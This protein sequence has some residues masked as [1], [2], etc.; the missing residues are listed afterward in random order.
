MNSSSGSRTGAPTGGQVLSAACPSR[1]LLGDI[2]SKWGVLVLIALSRGPARWSGLLRT[3]GG[4][5]EKM[6]AQTLRTLEEDGLVLRE[7]RPV[8]PPH[9]VYS[10]T[11][12]G[13]QVTGLLVPLVEW[14]QDHAAD[15]EPLP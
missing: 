9:V 4:I 10:L 3:I 2:T 7:A 15:T 11:E 8:V 5:S 1:R 13:R 6:L 14:V 12:E